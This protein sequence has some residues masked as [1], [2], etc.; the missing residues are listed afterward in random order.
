[1][2]VFYS[3]NVA[4]DTDISVR[5]GDNG[6]QFNMG[7][8]TVTRRSVRLLEGAVGHAYVAGRNRQ[9]AELAVAFD[10][11]LQTPSMRHEIETQIITP[12]ERKYRDAREQRS[13]KTAVTCSRSSQNACC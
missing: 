10:A 2:S 3:E 4:A 13:K 8:M 5:A 1:M 12:L 7:E 6:Q 9:Y 11:L